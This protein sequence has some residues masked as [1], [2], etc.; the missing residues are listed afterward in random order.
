MSIRTLDHPPAADGPCIAAPVLPSG[1]ALGRAGEDAALAHLTE[2]HGLELV[3]RN[4][5]VVLDELR[6]EL[7]LVLRDPISGTLVVCEVKSRTGAAG[8]DGAAATLGVRQQV[9]IRRLTTVLLAMGSLRASRV[10]FDLIALDT[11]GKGGAG[12]GPR[13][14][15]GARRARLTHLADAW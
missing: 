11:P 15:G 2:V 4:W 10:R 12:H 3:A 13:R 9:R 1:S 14:E 5:R 7:D 8:R 6:G